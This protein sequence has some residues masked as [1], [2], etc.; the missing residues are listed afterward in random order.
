M[1]R[2]RPPEP[3]TIQSPKIR[4]PTG[5]RSAPDTV[6]IEPILEIVDADTPAFERSSTEE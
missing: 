3:P 1:E 2:P 6:T 5:R 4:T